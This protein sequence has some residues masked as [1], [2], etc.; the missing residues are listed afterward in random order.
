MSPS[1]GPHSPVEE[2]TSQTKTRR[3]YLR[4]AAFAG[5]LGAFGGYGV[6]QLSQPAIAV[7]KPVN[8][9]TGLVEGKLNVSSY[10]IQYTDLDPAEDITIEY[11]LTIDG[12]L[13][14]ESEYQSHV[15]PINE[16]S[17]AV[18][19]GTHSITVP[20]GDIG[21]QIRFHHPSLGTATAATES[22]NAV[23]VTS[24]IPDSGITHIFETKN[25]TSEIQD[26]QFMEGD[27]TVDYELEEQDSYS[28]DESGEYE[29]GVKT[30]DSNGTVL[31]T[32][33]VTKE[34]VAGETP[35]TKTGSS[36]GSF[37]K[38]ADS[39]RFFIEQRDT[40]TKTYGPNDE[41]PIGTVT[42]SE[43]A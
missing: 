40:D 20:A 32:I 19:T 36:T 1:D 21:L 33:S 38:S 8:L 37:T 26:Y 5:G 39:W 27:Y 41:N 7:S 18:M 22:T 6:T 3:E 23:T 4:Y 10:E 29:M 31:E 25:G 28:S 34:F 16:S 13:Q 14:P 2:T 30:I 43:S 9:P 12:S 24:A 42:I 11:I 35:T 17:G 15:V